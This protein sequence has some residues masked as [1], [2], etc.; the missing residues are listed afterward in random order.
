MGL[1]VQ[2]TLGPD[3][4]TTSPHYPPAK[5][6]AAQEG[7]THSRRNPSLERRPAC[8]LAQSAEAKRLPYHDAIF[9]GLPPSQIRTGYYAFTTDTA[10]YAYRSPRATMGA[11]HSAL[12]VHSID[13]PVQCVAIGMLANLARMRNDSVAGWPRP[14]CKKVSGFVAASSKWA[15][16][17]VRKPHGFPNGA[18]TVKLF[19]E[20]EALAENRRERLLCH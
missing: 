13:S 1:P 14:W 9:G 3:R 10:P 12:S 16:P 7:L 5:R 17:D 18:P 20:D 8:S 4:L 6:Q 19:R 2:R 15:C 11:G